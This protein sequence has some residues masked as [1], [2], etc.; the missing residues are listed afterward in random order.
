MTFSPDG[1]LLAGGSP[2]GLELWDA[3]SGRPIR[4]LADRG[5]ANYGVAF[6][7]DGKLLLSTGMM[8]QLWDTATGQLR[9]SRTGPA[10]KVAFGPDELVMAL[11]TWGP[12]TVQ[13]LDAATG[14]AICSQEGT[15]DAVTFSL[16]GKRL[17]LDNNTLRD[18]ATGRPLCILTGH[19]G[20]GSTAALSPDGELLATA[21]RR[22]VH[23]R[24]TA[25]GELVHSLTGRVCPECGEGPGWPVA[26]SSDLQVLASTDCDG[27]MTGM[28]GCHGTVR[29]WDTATGRRL[30][31]LNG[32]DHGVAAVAFSPDRSLLATADWMGEVRLWSLIRSQP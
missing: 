31:V 19:E 14:E 3:A 1:A 16:Y 21:D 13:V 27:S 23:L 11:R 29:L 26:F 32:H 5:G 22:T 25:T 17:S 9:W 4:F 24:A 30:C 18:T 15:H 2:D 10:Q 7:R 28:N 12:L 8:I 6:S 20:A